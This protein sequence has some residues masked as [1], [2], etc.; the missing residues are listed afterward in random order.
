M[1]AIKYTL[2]I[3][4]VVAGFVT[5]LYDEN[6]KVGTISNNAVSGEFR[7]MGIAP[8][9]YDFIFELLRSRGALAVRVTTGLDDAHAPA[10]RAY[11][12]AGFSANLQSVTYYRKL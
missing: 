5:Y 9:M 8:R 3:D 10:R 12:K 11:E 4:G 6:L 1:G 2:K 7:G